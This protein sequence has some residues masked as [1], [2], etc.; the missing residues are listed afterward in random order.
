MKGQEMSRKVEKYAAERRQ[1]ESFLQEK[2]R[3][4]LLSLST[5]L[6]SLK[7]ALN[8]ATL[9]RQVLLRLFAQIL[10]SH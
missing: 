7:E 2:Y 9:A 10:Y 8:V 1:M 3:G 6:I 4:K 5:E